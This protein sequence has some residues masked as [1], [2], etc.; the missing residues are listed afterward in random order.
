MS[1]GL[2]RFLSGVVDTFISAPRKRAVAEPA[3]TIRSAPLEAPLTQEEVNIV[4]E[5]VAEGFGA[6]EAAHRIAESRGV[7]FTLQGLTDTDIESPR[8]LAAFQD[9]Q[10]DLPAFRL[11]MAV[12]EIEER[13]HSEY[14]S[15]GAHV[16]VAF[17]ATAQLNIVMHTS[18]HVSG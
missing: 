15:F 18:D 2:D 4:Y 5:T 12:R 13:I 8:A 6:L 3:R 9:E 11:A 1:N 10:G 7:E 16:Q 14:N 17:S